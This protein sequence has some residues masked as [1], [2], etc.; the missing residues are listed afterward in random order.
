MFNWMAFIIWTAL[1]S[2]FLLGFLFYKKKPEWKSA[3]ILEGFII[4]LFAEM[5]GLPL[6]IYILSSFFGMSD[7][8]GSENLRGALIGTNPS[9]LLF[10]VA[11]VILQ[12]V[13]FILVGI[14]WYRIYKANDTLITDGLYSHVRHPQ[15]LGLMMITFGMLVWWPTILVLFMWPILCAMYYLLARR[16]EKE[17][18]DKF[19][20]NYSKYKRR[21]NMFIPFT[22]P[23]IKKRVINQTR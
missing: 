10:V 22:K 18:R 16:E 21:V 23:R 7:I 11:A 4:A 6:S 19:G 2:I 20:D 15:Y 1:S 9:Q 17:M 5:F 3:G 13:G 8:A 14:G 12:L